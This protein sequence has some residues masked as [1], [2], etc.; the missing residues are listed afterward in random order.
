MKLYEIDQAISQVLENGFVMDEETGEIVFDETNLNALQME[1]ESK[2][3]GVAV[4]IKEL[5]AEEAALKAEE[6][7]LKE[8][9]ER[10]GK[11]ADRLLDFLNRSLTEKFKTARVE[12]KF[13]NSVA[14]EVDNAAAIPEGFTRQTVKI[15]PDKKKI[16]DAIMQGHEVPGA[17][18]V[19]KR[20]VKV[21]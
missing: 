10:A 17:H 13:T 16:K 11:K 18:L 5:R 7:A 1:R 21:K 12:I 14:V 20:T 4:W 8:R 2:I 19:K 15:D 9:R 3:E 6:T